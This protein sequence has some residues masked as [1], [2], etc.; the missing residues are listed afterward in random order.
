MPSQ[1][2]IEEKGEM[3]TSRNL[4]LK[5]LLTQLSHYSESVRKGKK[6]KGT[7]SGREG[8]EKIKEKEGDVICCF[9]INE[10]FI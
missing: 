2:M 10:R 4:T 6:E 7:K 5:D 3:V 1:S 9:Y 8:Y